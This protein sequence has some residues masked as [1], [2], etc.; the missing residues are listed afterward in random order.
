[1]KVLLQW[2]TD[3]PTDWLEIDS[4]NWRGIPKKNDPVGG[5]VI[6]GKPGWIN[7][8][9]VQGVEFTADHYAVED[10][11][12]LGCKVY[13][14]NDDPI[15]YLEGYKNA[16]VCEFLYLDYDPQMGGAINTRQTIT[17]YV[18]DEVRKLMPSE[19]YNSEI[20]SLV[21]FKKPLEEITRHGISLPDALY[22]RHE[23]N[24]RIAGWREWIEGIH[25]SE[26]DENGCIKP[27]RPQGRYVI[28]DGTRT[29]FHNNVL[30]AT[31]LHSVNADRENQL[32]LTAA[33][34]SSETSSNIG[35]A[36]DME[37]FVATTPANEPDHTTWP[38][39]VYRYQI[40]CTSV[41][42]NITYGLLDLGGSNGHFARVNS[43]LTTEVDSNQQGSAAFAG[44]GLKLAA[45][46]G[47]WSGT[48]QTDRFEILIAAIRPASH[49]NQSITLQLGE[50]DDFA[51]GPWDAPLAAV[52][53]S[54]FFGHN[55]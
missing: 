35:G 53:N 42:A 21:E 27:Q 34:A 19:I 46:T 50:A 2:A 51:D 55:F 29:Y 47:T 49:G 31:S 10:L 17:Y 54:V 24:R 37:A 4:S 33:G 40:D 15:D 6:N 43:T 45:Y 39:G 38:E 52:D 20:K 23:S 8:V 36:S 1:M 14:W 3:G 28:P 32:G 48:V 16:L 22:Q 11:P 30:V 44:N 5:E 41:G 7:R 12:E 26:L 18:Q 25:S 9:C 13:T